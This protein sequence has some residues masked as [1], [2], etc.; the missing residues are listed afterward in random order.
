ME[1]ASAFGSLKAYR[2][3]VNEELNG[4]CAFLEV[5]VY[6]WGVASFTS[7]WFSTDFLKL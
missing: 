5:L 7:H 1:I 6:V 2:F 4:S 3:E